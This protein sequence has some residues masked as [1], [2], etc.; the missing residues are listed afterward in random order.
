MGYLKIITA[1]LIWSSLGIFVRKIELPIASIVFYPSLFA[2]IFQSAILYR[3][4]GFSISTFKAPAPIFYILAPCSLANTLLYYYAFTH[5]TIAN[6]VLTHYTAPIFVAL[7]APLF[8]KEKSAKST[9]LA[10]IIS[11]IGLWLIVG[12]LSVNSEDFRGVIAGAASGLAYGIIILLL[13][14]LSQTHSPIFIVFIQNLIITFLL[15]PFI[16]KTFIPV[17]SLF[18]LIAMGLIHS[19]LA[20]LL[21]VQGV[22]DVKANEAA[23]LGYFEPMGA[24]ILALVFLKETPGLKALFGGLLILYSGFIVIKN[25]RINNS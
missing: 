8:L 10:I 17:Y 6:A 12:G 3:N 18:Y 16:T 7:A 23:I 15:L 14:T 21:Y 11:S 1:I 25:K 24:I 19:T 2:S 22:R 9:W 20:P 13:R 4:K 5:T